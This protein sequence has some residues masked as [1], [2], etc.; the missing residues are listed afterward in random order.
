MGGFQLSKKYKDFLKYTRSKGDILE[1]T[2]FA[3]KTT[4]GIVKFMLMVAKSDKQD[5]ILSGLDLG[6]IEKNII[7]PT[8]GIL[9]IFGDS[10]YGGCVQ[11]RSDGGGGVTLPHIR[12][13]TPVGEKIIYTLGY[14][15]RDRWKKALGG[16]YG[17]VYI[18][19]ANI[20]NMDYVREIMMRQNYFI[21][22]LNPDDPN[23]PIYREYIN[24]SRPLIRWESETPVGLLNELREP[25]QEGW[26]H[27]YF[28]YDHN[29]GL[30][31]EKRASLLGSAPV[32]SKQYKNK[33]LGLRGRHTG[34]VFDLE[35]KNVLPVSYLMDQQKQDKWK[36]FKIFTCGVDTSYS[37][38]S[39]D[40][41]AFSFVGITECG[42]KVTL[43]VLTVNN[44]VL[45]RNGLNPL[46]PSDI[47]PKLFKFLEKNRERWGFARDVF[48]DSADSATITECEKYKRL[49]G[50]LYK[51]I[52]AWKK[53]KILDRIMLTQGWLTHDQF[54]IL[55]D[56]KVMI[57]EFN[58]YSWQEDKQE[59]E[60]GNDHTINADQYAW[61]PYKDKIGV[62]K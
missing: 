53:T 61:L 50:C 21:M 58:L 16:Q 29:K 24:H 32:G 17:C 38:K 31:P 11:Y 5:H 9:D 8:L 10:R 57:D 47:P 46:A 52:P 7:N 4:I 27:W 59:P 60:D 41:I 1:G 30:T 28:T 26:V 62:T 35:D 33:I 13:Q 51:F 23:L 22:T 56:C 15:N 42:K 39:D 18:D 3:G 36:P 54:F 37:R 34:L 20:A 45:V 2:T 19:E 49:T 12:Y 44:T 25:R 48:I 6:T 40:T 43:D 14:D 55:S